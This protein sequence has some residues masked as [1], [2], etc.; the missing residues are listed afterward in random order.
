MLHMFA[1]EYAYQYWRTFHRWGGLVFI[2][3]VLRVGSL[4]GFIPIGWDS[5][6]YLSIS[7]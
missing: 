5:F 3:D 7:D 4:L 1:Y 2:V 6:C